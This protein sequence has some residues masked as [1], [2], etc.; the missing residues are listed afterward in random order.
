MTRA[1]AAIAAAAAALHRRDPAGAERLLRQLLAHEPR[2]AEAL[3][4]LGVCLHQQRRNAEAREVLQQA[5]AIAPDNALVQMNLGS[6]LGAIGEHQAGIDALRRA[7]ELDPGQAAAWFNLG[8]ALKTQGQVAAAVAPLERAVAINPS[9]HVAQTVLG[10]TLKIIGRTAA[11]AAAYRAALNAQPRAGAA[12]W[13]LANIKT[14]AFEPADIVAMDTILADPALATETRAQILFAQARAQEQA[15]E[16]DRAF[17]ALTAANRLQRQRLPWERQA[18]STLAAAVSTA[19]PV[20]AN[21]DMAETD[22]G[23]EVLFVVSL[24]R[25]GS[26]LVEQILAAHPE[27]AGASELPDLPQVIAAESRRRGQPFP[28]WVAA[29]TAA[30]WQRL[31]QEY[32]DRTRRWRGEKARF[33]DKLPNNFLYVGAAFAMLPGAHAVACVRDGMDTC[34]SCYQQY[35]ARGQEFSYD[36]DD[37][38][39]YYLDY[40]RLLRHWSRHYPGRFSRIDYETLVGD[41]EPAIRRLLADCGLAFDPAC[42]SPHRAER[43]VRTASAA[44]VREPIDRRGIGRWHFYGEH[45]HGLQMALHPG[46]HRHD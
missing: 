36:L 1:N 38:A 9:H 11:A 3:R 5:L 29:A 18:F 23:R 19:F 41:P 2:H 8:K 37:L 31:G 7:T 27:V 40:L 46:A 4:L 45:L 25:S 30:D 43:E 13:G 10:D 21:A 17:A 16:P 6:V 28:Q 32:L 14:V 24:P 26:T 15:G 33:T 34:L 35:F 42:L 12:W 39:A 44:Q 20:A 22:F